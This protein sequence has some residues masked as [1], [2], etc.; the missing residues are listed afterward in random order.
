[1]V[2]GVSWLDGYIGA[3]LLHPYAG[4]A[5]GVKA[6]SELLGYMDS[7]VRY[8]DMPTKHVLVGHAGVTEMCRLAYE[9]SP[10]LEFRVLSSQSNG[11]MYTFEH[12][13]SG[14]NTT[15]IGSIPASGRRFV[16]RGVSLG[17][18]SPNG[19][20]QEHRDYL[21]DFLRQVGALPTLD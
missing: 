10:D 1:M 6:L 20:V 4:S 13:G 5:E 18:L 8:E 15:A 7:D 14:T 16:I 12:E 21:A 19:L 17:T 11:S 3:W 9:W 2:G